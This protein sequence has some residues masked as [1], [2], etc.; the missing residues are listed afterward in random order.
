MKTLLSILF[1][2]FIY[3]CQTKNNSI[4]LQQRE[5]SFISFDKFFLNAFDLN[6]PKIEYCYPFLYSNFTSL[7]Q[8][9]SL[10]SYLCDNKLVD[11]IGC[12]S[13]NLKYKNESV[14]I[15][16]FNVI[17]N[18]YVDPSPIMRIELLLKNDTIYYN[19]QNFLKQTTIEELKDSL[20]VT[21]SKSISDFCC[22]MNQRRSFLNH[23][24]SLKEYQYF[25]NSFRRP[26]II[27]LS[28][29]SQ[30][31]NLGKVL[32]ISYD[33]YIEQLRIVIPNSYEKSINDLNRFEYKI[34]VRSLFFS[35][36]IIED[37]LQKYNP[38][39]QIN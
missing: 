16:A 32:N 15:P 3:S 33:A 5:L 37:Y 24:D 11:C 38:P 14:L 6:E 22:L 19:K 35:I 23:P 1:A 34:F 31:K 9:D 2:F 36:N 10:R 8:I 13:L 39:D 29:N 20:S 17:C 21:F 25:N 18:C 12:I 28:D 4:G 30:I 26:L 7:E 27:T